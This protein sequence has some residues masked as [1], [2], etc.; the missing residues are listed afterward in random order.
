MRVD[1]QQGVAIPVLVGAMAKPLEP[2]GSRN[3]VALANSRALTLAEACFCY[4]P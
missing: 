1:Q 4:G 2:V 3:S